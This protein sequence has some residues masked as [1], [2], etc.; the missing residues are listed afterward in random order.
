MEEFLL[1]ALTV[2]SANGEVIAGIVCSDVRR[3]HHERANQDGAGALLSFPI[4]QA[5]G[6]RVM[7]E[8]QPVS[9]V[10]GCPGVDALAAIWIVFRGDVKG[11]I[12]SAPPDHEDVVPRSEEA[13]VFGIAVLREAD[14]GDPQSPVF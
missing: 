3:I 9:I 12:C 7:A 11:L 13:L 14:E 4:L 10:D 5:M 2:A 8:I 6:C 1:T